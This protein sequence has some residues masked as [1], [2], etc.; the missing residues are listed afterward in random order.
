M[1]SETY[2]PQ[3]Q[4]KD[5]ILTPGSPCIPC[6]VSDQHAAATGTPFKDRLVQNLQAFRHL[7]TAVKYQAP[8]AGIIDLDFGAI[9]LADTDKHCVRAAH[10]LVCLLLLA[11]HGFTVQL[12]PWVKAVHSQNASPALCGRASQQKATSRVMEEKAPWSDRAV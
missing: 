11:A 10:W 9:I 5:M 3:L 2:I 6:C 1:L 4:H 8:R 7:N 12:D